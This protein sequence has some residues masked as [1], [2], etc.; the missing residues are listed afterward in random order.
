MPPGIGFHDVEV[1]RAEGKGPPQLLLS[2]VAARAARA[3]GVGKVMLTLTH[4]G[5]L[6]AATVLL[7]RERSER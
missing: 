6:A 1:V 3:L 2:G 7:E 4:D 5:G